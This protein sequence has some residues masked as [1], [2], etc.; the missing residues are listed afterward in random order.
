MNRKPNFANVVISILVGLTLLFQTGFLSGASAFAQGDGIRRSIHSQ[1]GK[2]SFLGA[3]PS[4]PIRMEAAMKVGLSP[5]ARGIAILETYGREFGLK[6]PQEE[7]RFLSSHETEGRG[8]VRYQQVYQGIPIMAGELIVNTNGNGSLLS[9]NGE[10]SPDMKL[11]TRPKLDAEDARQRAL[12]IVSQ[13]Y[14][15]AEEELI[16][17]EP[18]LWIFDERLIQNNA[19]Q[20]VHL[21][22]RMEV[23]SENAPLRELV[24]VNA[25]NGKISLHFNQVD[26][27][28]TAEPTPVKNDVIEPVVASVVNPIAAPSSSVNTSLSN[29][30]LPARYVD[31]IAGVDS[32]ACNLPANPCKNIQ[33]AIM[34]ANAGDTIAVTSGSYK[35]VSVPGSGNVETPGQVTPRQVILL[36]KTVNLSGGWNST[37]E[38]Q[39]GISILD[40]EHGRYGIS[41]SIPVEDVTEINHFGI[42]NGTA[43]IYKFVGEL[44]IKNSSIFNNDGIGLWNTQLPLTVENVTISNNGGHGIYNNGTAVITNA[45]ISGNQNIGL[46]RIGGVLTL[47]NTIIANN[48][49]ADCAGTIISE[50]Y[51]IIGNTAGCTITAVAGDQF[52]PASPLNL[53]VFLPSH[54]YQPLLLDSPAIEAAYPAYCPVLDQRGIERLPVGDT[55]CDIGAYEYT[56]PGPAT[57]IWVEDGDNQRVRIETAYPKQLTVAAL[58]S[59]GS[60]VSGVVVTFTAPASGPSVTFSGGGIS[61]EPLTTDE[62]GTISTSTLTANS[63]FGTFNIAADTPGLTTASFML[64]NLPWKWYVSTAGDNNNSCKTPAEPCATIN[65]A[66]GK[67]NPTDTIYVAEGTYTGDTISPVVTIQKSLVL[68]GGWDS[69]FATQTGYSTIDGQNTRGGMAI[70][71]PY[72]VNLIWFEFKNGKGNG[73]YSYR[74]TLTVD[75]SYFHDNNDDGGIGGGISNIF[76]KLYV[77][78]STFYN[79]SARNGGG[80][81]SS[82]YNSYEVV[83]NYVTISGNRATYGGGIFLNDPGVFIVKNS[84]I[85]NN[86]AATEG[87]DCKMYAPMTSISGGYNIVGTTCGTQQA[88]DL[89]NTDPKLGAFLPEQGYI[90]LSPES[91]AI[92]HSDNTCVADQRGVAANGVCDAG[93]FEFITNTGEAASIW[94]VDGDTQRTPPNNAFLK[95][96][97]AVILDSQGNPVNGAL[98]NFSAPDSGASAV[99]QG[100]GIF[101]ENPLTTNAVG[102]VT[103]STVIANNLSGGYNIT[104][105]GGTAGIATFSM[106]NAAWY[107]SP[108]GNDANSCARIAEPCATINGAI[109]KAISGDTI[110]V[111]QDVY[112]GTGTEVVFTDK[113]IHLSGGWNA[114]FDT[115]D[116]YTTVDGEDARQGIVI[117]KEYVSTPILVIID[118]FIV[119]N[120]YIGFGSGGGILNSY[121][122]LQLS[123]SILEENYAP[124]GGG[125]LNTGTANLNRVTIRYNRADSGGG[126]NSGGP[127]TIENSAIYGNFSASSGGGVQNSNALTMRNVSIIGNEAQSN[128][129]GFVTNSSMA[130]VLNNVT[131]S[132][133]IAGEMGGG[134]Q[135][136][137][138]SYLLPLPQI[139]NSIVAGNEAPL[140]NDCMSKFE[141][142]YSLVQ[143][144]TSCTGATGTT[145]KFGVDPQ[146]MG[147][148]PVQGYA[149]LRSSSPA[150]NGGNP[151]APDSGGLTCAVTDQRGA[152]RTICDMGAYEFIESASPV[153]IVPV[154]YDMR[155]PPNTAFDMPLKAAVLDAAGSPVVNQTQITITFRAPTDGGP[156]GYF[157]EPANNETQVN[158]DADGVATSGIFTANHV[159]GDY[160]VTV[161]GDTLEPGEIPL[162][163]FAWFV[164]SDG[165]DTNI[166][167]SPASA[168]R[169]I[170]KAFEK[171]RTGDSIYVAGGRY[172]DPTA[173]ITR[174]VKIVGSWREDFSERG[175]PTVI[176]GQGIRSGFTNLALNTL[177]KRINIENCSSGISNLGSVILDQV[178]ITGCTGAGIYHG[179]GIYS[180]NMTLLNS[181]ISNNRGGGLDILSGNVTVKNSTIAYNK[182]VYPTDLGGGIKNWGGGNVRLYNS[183]VAHNTAPTAPDCYTYPP[184]GGSIISGGNNI[185]GSTSGCVVTAVTGDRFNVDPQISP[186]FSLGY[187]PLKIASPAIGGGNSLTC[188]SQD[189]REVE[190]LADSKCDIGAYEYKTPD[191]P[192]ALLAVA[193]QVRRTGINM[194]FHSVLQAVVVDAFGTPVGGIGVLFTAPS[195]GPSGTFQGTGG[196][197]ESLVT[198]ANGFAISSVFVANGE[199]GDYMVSAT[200]THPNLPEPVNFQLHNGAWLVNVVGGIDSNDCLSLSTP[201]QTIEGVLGKAEFTS[202]DMVWVASGS[203]P[204]NGSMLY[205]QTDAI[206]V[207]GWNSAFTSRGVASV[208]RPSYILYGDLTFQNFVFTGTAHLQNFGNL[209]IQDSSIYKTSL[210]FENEYTGIMTLSNVTVSGH[211]TIY[212]PLYNDGGIMYVL[213]STI[214]KNKATFAG[215]IFNEDSSDGKVY[216][217]DTIL[218][219]NTATYAG[220]Y[221]GDDC[222]GDF[223][224]LGHNIIGTIG[225]KP[226]G[227]VY[228]CRVAWMDSDIYGDNAKPILASTVINT[229]VK[230][231]VA[232][233]QWYHDLKF[234]GPAIDRGNE[235]LPGS[236]GNA[237]PATDQLGTVRPQGA[238]CDIGAVEYKFGQYPANFLLATYTAKNGTTLPG[239]KLCE[240][241]NA[242]CLGTTDTQAKS[243]HK[244]AYS[245]YN[246]YKLWHARNSLDGNGF[247]IVST[248]HYGSGYK[249]AFWNGHMLVFGDGYGFAMADDVVAHELTHGVTQFESN[250]FYWYQSGAI[251]ES[252]SDL[253]GEA[254]DQ[255]NR[256]GTDTVSVKWLIGE[257][258]ANLGAI[259]SMSNPPDFG[260]PDSITSPLYCDSGDC[261]KDNGG[262]HTNS[263]VNNKAV[264]LLVNGGTFNGRTVTKLGWTKT[265]EI[266]YEAQANLLTSGSDYLDLYNILYQACQNK[267]GVKGITSQDC[268]EVRD[269][270][271]AVRMNSQ[272]AANFNPD[273]PFCPAGTYRV[274]PD[275]FFDDF[276]TGSDGWT[277]GKIKGQSAWSL[278]SANAAS[279]TASLWADDAYG[280]TDSYAATKGIN[281]P[282]GSKPYLHF[283]H[284]Y[285]FETSNT[286]YYDG[287]VLEYSLNNGRTWVDAKALFSSGQNYKGTIKTANANPLGGRTAFVG[288][289]HGYVDSRYN[290]TTLAGKTVR[291]R[292]RMGTDAADYVS[293][294]FVDDVRIYRCVASP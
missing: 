227:G 250:L 170:G 288:Q 132:G 35:Y 42:K 141:L 207:G 270:T 259:R 181:T 273:T 64:E 230:Q 17:S 289:S 58:D 114:N 292:W 224:S 213:S 10:V 127:L 52:D 28:W 228:D 27:S 57:G 281:I 143:D 81:Y 150:V 103:T 77:N 182:R 232:T 238:R 19:T 190:R 56:I 123:D 106:V 55:A 149:P 154:T 161:I 91:P 2:L 214:T 185:I 138:P 108:T 160:M 94:A 205:I 113:A 184:E 6:N 215:G 257:D 147:F 93:A 130:V 119:H 120:G 166:C 126:V 236:G 217:K 45:T 139:N 54:G 133:N 249:N 278:S 290:L 67:A 272:P 233:K 164:K 237:C 37:F 240:S 267:V 88:T 235:A 140:A 265:L 256:L 222:R 260:D 40:A 87:S 210:S 261:L 115:Q 204:G 248:V 152:S 71:G 36:N 153:R 251:N 16:V 8:T 59:L 5:E 50:G 68:S 84:I 221:V 269:A 159:L 183:I 79:N 282:V 41:I 136:D 137:R 63:E 246:Q 285:N 277:I 219:G 186:L 14:K 62:T 287:G 116:G 32:G 125:L 23:T 142:N 247:Q 208:I 192:V 22:W 189:Q 196:I 47:R 20:P 202:G 242:T 209:V 263:G 82:G 266:Y 218:A 49:S 11:D 162:S 92:N 194:P 206:L 180:H 146:L 135:N 4:S 101:T 131:I 151:A 229:T 109:A 223:I 264:Y 73:I 234:G 90:P 25:Q 286:T 29:P 176:D 74:A 121:E 53:G 31:G 110:F 122:T 70:S 85:A 80:V 145:N 128:G 165:N 98:V 275:V 199:Y 294:W 252:F 280:K 86:T 38:S 258:I 44:V 197:T 102:A 34:N 226:P 48:T 18:E 3:D 195:S 117:E 158:L 26:T 7:L 51:N 173:Q 203:Y 191:A 201:C 100:T 157:V 118:H 225:H 245:T 129:G 241:N 148:L 75:H 96:L 104:A 212:T 243:V 293:G 105:N 30:A 198:D 33:F 83:L 211:G 284:S 172:S 271:V 155:T 95:P 46:S 144:I 1:T 43:G 220:D 283:T 65:A 13:T 255:T 178:S 231:D 72:N 254:V 124:S 12:A 174:R 274:T 78:H 188:T 107:V 171:S 253:W 244:Y 239:T 99:F 175:M 39:T 179:D 169:T 69:A 60:P 291:F 15:L 112:T 200:S 111:T 262:V 61:E 167:T 177:I 187:H 268:Q 89:F 9:I 163:N 216:L 97:T 279:G 193:P 168:C 66:V 134:I 76:G 156:S 21:V 24:L 276:E